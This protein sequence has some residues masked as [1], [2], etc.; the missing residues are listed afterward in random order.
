MDKVQ[1][2]RSDRM[3]TWHKRRTNDSWTL[4]P[5]DIIYL[6]DIFKVNVRVGDTEKLLTNNIVQPEPLFQDLEVKQLHLQ[7]KPWLRWARRQVR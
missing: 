1:K 6:S 4:K 3:K 5:Q 7:A 2:L